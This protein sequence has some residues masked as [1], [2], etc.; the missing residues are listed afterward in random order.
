MALQDNLNKLANWANDWKMKFNHDKCKIMS[1][2]QKSYDVNQPLTLIDLTTGLRYDL[3][4]TAS[5]RDLGIQVTNNLKWS[6]QTKKAANNATR[7][8]A[9][10]SV[11][12]N[13]KD[14]NFL[15]II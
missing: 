5:E 13:C 4:E 2:G 14:R 10:L 11:K 6:E 7:V 15:V 3:E 9:I 1:I 8:L 12:I